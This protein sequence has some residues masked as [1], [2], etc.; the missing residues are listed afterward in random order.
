MADVIDVRDRTVANKSAI[1]AKRPASGD[2]FQTN[3]SLARSSQRVEIMDSS[4]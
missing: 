3:S 1:F 2:P 4:N